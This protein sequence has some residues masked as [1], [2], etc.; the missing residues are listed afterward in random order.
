MRAADI[1]VYLIFKHYNLCLFQMN[2]AVLIACQQSARS[3]LH[4]TLQTQELWLFH[5]L[6]WHRESKSHRSSDQQSVHCFIII[7]ND[8]YL[9]VY[10]TEDI[11]LIIYNIP[12]KHFKICI[13]VWFLDMIFM[14]DQNSLTDEKGIS[15]WLWLIW[16]IDWYHC[17]PQII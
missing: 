7:V 17:M 4:P 14:F 5:T 3:L 15:D 13:H 11:D 8:W 16:L 6:Q 1:K 10:Y 2:I 12:G 9:T